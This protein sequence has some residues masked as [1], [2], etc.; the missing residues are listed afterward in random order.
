MTSRRS[1]QRN[2]SGKQ[3]E[4]R[5]NARPASHKFQGRRSANEAGPQAANRPKPGRKQTPRSIKND[6]GDDRK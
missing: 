6:R 2:A 5:D 4:D 3:T 1:N